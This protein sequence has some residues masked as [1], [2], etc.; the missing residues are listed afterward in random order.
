MSL[1]RITDVKFHVQPQPVHRGWL[2]YFVAAVSMGIGVAE[3]QEMRMLDYWWVMPEETPENAPRVIRVT[4][5]KGEKYEEVYAEEQL[6]VLRNSPVIM[7]ARLERQAALRR[8]AVSL[9][10][11]MLAEDEALQPATAYAEAWTCVFSRRWLTAKGGEGSSRLEDM[12]LRLASEN[13]AL[14]LSDEERQWVLEALIEDDDRLDSA[15]GRRLLEMLARNLRQSGYGRFDA[16][17]G[18]NDELMARFTDA[19]R[20]EH[21]SMA[22]YRDALFKT[23]RGR[24]MQHSLV[25]Y[26]A[27]WGMGMGG[28]R[29]V[30]RQAPQKVGTTVASGH[31]ASPQT[32]TLVA[33]PQSPTATSQPDF[34][35]GMNTSAG[36][37]EN[38]LAEAVPLPEKEV[39]DDEEKKKDEELETD[40]LTAPAPR[41]RLMMRAVG[42]FQAASAPVV[43][44]VVPANALDNYVSGL[45]NGAMLKVGANQIATLHL[46][47]NPTSLYGALTWNPSSELW[48]GGTTINNI[49]QFG[50]T[51]YMALASGSH[52]Y[53]ERNGMDTLSLVVNNK[54]GSTAYMHAETQDWSKGSVRALAASG[55]HQFSK[56]QGQ[57]SITFMGDVSGETTIYEFSG[58]PSA[59]DGYTS[60]DSGFYGGIFMAG[61]CDSRV[62][63]NISG[64]HWQ[65]AYVDLTPGTA[66]AYNRTG[67]ASGTVLNIL[68]NTQLLGLDGGTVESTVTSNSGDYSYTLTLGDSSGTRHEYNGTFHGSYYSSNTASYASAAPL[69][70]TKIY[71]NEQVMG[72]DATGHR[73]FNVVRVEGGTLSFNNSL[74]A[75]TAQAVTGGVLNVGGNLNITETYASTDELLV[76]GA[77][78]QVKVGGDITVA[79][80]VS[81]RDGGSL[82][83]ANLNVQDKLSVNGGS[84]NITGLTTAQTV[85]VY[86]GGSLTTEDLQDNANHKLNV[87]IGNDS[88]TPSTLTVKGDLEADILRLRSDG[89]LVTGNSSNLI[90]EA[91]VHGGAHWQLEGASNTL[92]GSLNIENA[93]GGISLSSA[94]GAILTLPGTIS[95]AAAGWTDCATPIFELAG[96]ALDFSRGV[97]LTNLGFTFDSSTVIK[98]AK[99]QSGSGLVYDAGGDLVY[100][101]VMVQSGGETYHAYLGVTT[102]DDVNYVTISMKE[103][104]EVGSHPFNVAMGKLLYLEMYQDASDPAMPHKAFSAA[105]YSQPGGWT[106]TDESENLLQFSQ[107]N[108]NGGGHVYFAETEQG[109]DYAAH[110]HFGGRINLVEAGTDAGSLHGEIGH[111]GNWYLDGRLSGAGKLKLVA[112]HE[113]GNTDTTAEEPVGSAAAGDT[114]KSTTTWNYGTASTFTFTDTSAKWLEKGSTVSLANTHGGIVQLNIGNVN[115]ATEGDTRWKDTV[116]DLRNNAETDPATGTSGKAGELVLGVMG[117]AT[118]AGLVGSEDS[119]VV[120]DVPQGSLR[121]SPTLTVGTDGEDYTF[122]GKVGSGNFY[123]GGAASYEETVINTYGPNPDGGDSSEVV[124]TEKTS[125]A[126]NMVRMGEGKLSLTKVGSNTQS[127]T[128]LVNLDAVAVQGGSL[129]LTGE[130]TSMNSLSM[131]RG[132]SMTTGALTL[133]TATLDGAAMTVN[134]NADIDS[135]TLSNGAS[136]TS[137]YDVAL[138]AVVLTGSE[139]TAKLTGANTDIDALT[140]GA[141]TT[142]TTSAAITLHSAVF[143]G[144][145]T[146]KTGSGEVDMSATPITLVDIAG[147]S[148]NITS[149]AAVS[150]MSYLNFDGNSTYTTDKA[151]FNLTGNNDT[152]KLSSSLTLTNVQGLQQGKNIALFSGVEN[153]TGLSD[154]SIYVADADNTYYAEYYYEGNTVYLKIGDKTTAGILTSPEV[155]YI[156]SGEPVGHT[157]YGDDYQGLRM[158]NVWRADG[159][160]ENTGWHEQRAA[161]SVSPG[162]YVNGNTVTF[163]DTDVHG[164]NETN[165]EVYIYGKVAPGKIYV[166]AQN[167]EALMGAGD[168]ELR[169]GYAFTGHVDSPNAGITDFVDEDG[170]L[171]RTSITKTGDAVLILNTANDFSGGIEVRDGSL[172]LSRPNASGT[173]VITLYTDCTWTDYWDNDGG[174]DNFTEVQRTGAELMVNYEHVYDEV[175]A[176]RNPVVQNTVILKTG[177][178]ENAA[179][180]MAT[181]SYARA[182][183]ESANVDDD[184]HNVPRHWRNLSITGGLYGAGSDLLLRGYTSCWD[185]GHDQCYISAFTINNS[186]LDKTLVNESELTAFTGTV[187]LA[188]TVNTSRLSND[189]TNARTAGGV[190]LTLSDNTFAKG[191]IDLTREQVVHNLGWNNSETRQSYTNILVVNGNV[192]VGALSG[193]FLNNAW[194]Y[195]WDSGNKDFARDFKAISQEDERWRLR[196][197]TG[198]ETTLRL[199]LEDGEEY[200]YSGAMGYAQSYTQPQQSHIYFG[201]GMEVPGDES[202]YRASFLNAGSFSYAKESLSLVKSASSSQ[203]IHSALLNNVSVYKGTLGFNN[204]DLRGNLNLVAGSTLKLGVTSEAGWDGSSNTADNTATVGYNG[205]AKTLT[206]ITPDYELVGDVQSPISEL[207]SARVEGNVTLASDSALTFISSLLPDKLSTDQLTS[208]VNSS[209]ITPLLDVQGVLTLNSNQIINLSFDNVTFNLNEKYYIAGADQIKVGAQGA[210]AFGTQTVTLGYGYFGTLYTVYADGSSLGSEA[211]LAQ[212]GGI[213]KSGAGGREYLVMQVTGDPRH[214]WSGNI[215]DIQQDEPSSS[216]PPAPYVW[217]GTSHEDKLASLATGVYD[218]RWKENSAFINGAVVLFGNLYQPKGWTEKDRL[219]S[220]ATVKVDLSKKWAGTLVQNTA[221]GLAAKKSQEVYF[222]LDSYSVQE[223]TGGSA[224]QAVK[225]QGEVAPFIVM[226]NPSYEDASTGKQLQDDTN[227]YFYGT[228]CIRNATQAELGTAGF[229]KSWFTMLHKT[230][231]GTTIMAL[232]NRYTGGS[233]LQGGTVQ[234]LDGSI[235]HRGMMVMQHVNALGHVYDATT[236]GRAGEW[237]NGVF[238]PYE[239]TITL[240][241]GAALLADFD[242]ADFVGNYHEENN[243][244]LGKAMATTTINNKVEVNVYA[245]PNNASYDTLIDGRLLNSADKKLIIRELVGEADTVLQLTGVS[246][247]GDDA[248]RQEAARRAIKEYAAKDGNGQYIMVDGKYQARGGGDLELD[249]FYYGVF[250]VLDPGEFYGTV[251]MCGHVWGQQTHGDGKVQLDIMSTNKSDPGADWTNAT[252]DLSVKDGTERTVLALDVMSNGE[253]CKLNSI[254]GT[255]ERD[256]KG[257]YLGSSSVLNMS[258]HN[259]ATLELTG[260]RSGKYEG[261]LGYGNFQVAVNYGGY[262]ENQQG[263]T[264]HHYGAI[265]EGSLNL[266]KH[267]DSTVQEVRRAWLNSVEVEGGK[268][269]VNEA[270]VA[271]DIKSGDGT[272]V[273]VGA[274]APNT[275]Y[276]LA[277]GKG[278]T[279]AMNS[280]FAE[281]GEKTDAW[282]DLKAGVDGVA[283]V[284]LEDGATL[285][286]REDWYTIKPIDFLSGASVTVNT[287]NFAIDPYI[288]ATN[289]VFGKY[290]H[291]HIIQLL[292]S[293]SGMDVKLTFNNRLTNPDAKDAYVSTTVDSPYIGYA[294]INDFNF[295][296]GTENTLTVD[297][298]TVLQVLKN[299][300]GVEGDVDVLVEGRNATLQIVD[301]VVSYNDSGVGATSDSMQQYINHLVLGRNLEVD[302]TTDPLHRVNN[303]QLFLGGVEV[304]TL[305]P[306]GEDLLQTVDTADMQVV[307]SSRHNKAYDELKGMSY[308]AAVQADPALAEK[309]YGR[310]EHLH[311]DMRGTTASIGG[312]DGHRA[313]LANVHVDMAHTNINHKIHHA[314]LQNSLV[315]LMEDCTVNLAE[316]V[317]LKADSAVRGV[318]VDYNALTVS[319]TTWSDAMKAGQTG[320]L[321]ADGV[322]SAQIETEVRTSVNTTVELTFAANRG[323]YE[324]GNSRILVL[325]ANQLLGV[326]VSGNGL[327]LQLTADSDRF[328]DWGYN[329]HAQYVAVQIGGGS[330]QFLYEDDNVQWNSRYKDM[331][332]SQFVLLGADGEQRKGVWVTANDVYNN[333]GR[334]DPV[335][336]HLLYF[337]VPEPATATLS[338]AALVA[339]CARRR[340]KSE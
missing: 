173:G 80:D 71:G 332:D 162:V 202:Y 72:A 102:D 300:S 131:S 207:A 58:T 320:P 164:V 35:A 101:S 128:G 325:Q 54:N 143:Y 146:W 2:R 178:G 152:L 273:I 243:L 280:T 148:V 221:E 251:T 115:I 77:D 215:S 185:G 245:D 105:S 218:Y 142:L 163:R 335:S 265:G 31:V 241:N 224:Y 210:S 333:T 209:E 301:R 116:I 86:G 234:M 239:S 6:G 272:R 8:E 275:L 88:G 220:A 50:A 274:A 284:R 41:L 82:Q 56:L 49:W 267:G 304:K 338:L 227:Y 228:G 38:F 219:T 169:Y 235:E 270:L 110:R 167:D 9:A 211:A 134:G 79:D 250:K 37:V 52:L 3:A 259:A 121:T 76:S 29:A 137:S 60:A 331:I 188:N 126:T 145:A 153:V 313:E 57:G 85:S 318:E 20:H 248:S 263:T 302:T 51:S 236:Q 230:G 140:L 249:R 208:S 232:D 324:V 24:I 118:I 184:F 339:L 194:Q 151:L 269:V 12:L 96:V 47:W 139:T 312:A 150:G 141:G 196:V 212:N 32:Q 190:Q 165:R 336:T 69:N 4:G 135:I 268:F 62:Q 283:Y 59:A 16:V 66:S 158:G 125:S 83:G 5:E 113:I 27:P 53:L 216:N 132:T 133:G 122:A 109:A 317:L 129:N 89:V 307:I 74:Q 340:R 278:G 199:G 26:H 174:R 159:S 175:S 281:E 237:E 99:I 279:L 154:T 39:E 305:A 28:G 225:V 138:G 114:L 195:S 214:T 200:I 144:S 171:T 217:F 180:P 104:H 289:D 242:D 322:G 261:V 23:H 271:R 43:R 30:Y 293:M 240:M 182:A 156:W 13:D 315:H 306:T 329:A 112:H 285:S 321:A 297:S 46:G 290:N 266:L 120:S 191:K 91:H 22:A 48:T 170:K 65:N 186:Q 201:D 257:N 197:V 213:D 264:Q 238:K 203:Y 70:L 34:T 260:T 61:S 246:F 73:A 181:I 262:T 63:L 327:T 276:A 183:Y 157:I 111:W 298:M 136:L 255:I 328:L 187:K 189:N 166:N 222:H 299:N 287:H 67:T 319:P 316:T 309:A 292:G 106:G 44:A 223:F 323:V 155:G 231:T 124:S 206:V 108:L 204:L 310:V 253:F 45:V 288:T 256:A 229:D 81:V 98:F 160:A 244:S 177:S 149:S 147:A 19:L 93:S 103:S 198:S 303:G 311:V 295:L 10:R 25:G 286:A 294:A 36:S 117:D 127:F 193:Q 55:L 277:V 68:G 205:A 17:A 176:Y 291:S 7:Q 84:V 326:D 87:E 90:S 18:V 282:K 97:T 42:N 247:A 168:A 75:A 33:A 179:D 334:V 40:S 15:E 119:S 254:T 258:R 107:I 330:G 308:A 233:I 226:I 252:V 78:S 21:D 95:F 1:A 123:T 337:E 172:Y 192:E 100:N 64:A 94:S 161:Y 14:A 130:S 314:T 11:Q 92:H 296:R